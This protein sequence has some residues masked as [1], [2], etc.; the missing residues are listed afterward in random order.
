[1]ARLSKKRVKQALHDTKGAVYLAAKKLRCSHTAVYNYVNKYPDIAEIKEYYDE[2]T[3]DIAETGLRECVIE[4]EPWA[5]KYQL[6]TKGKKRGYI[7]TQEVENTGNQTIT[8]TYDRSE[9]LDTSQ[10]P[11]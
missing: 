1:M 3:N 8:V 9:P 7:Q 10:E 5:I 4:K 2:E 11:E 6:S